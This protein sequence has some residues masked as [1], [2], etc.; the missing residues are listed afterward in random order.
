MKVN[1]P[2]ST[3]TP[4]TQLANTQE[5]SLTP[6]DFG[7]M[8]KD[9]SVEHKRTLDMRKQNAEGRDVLDLINEQASKGGKPLP[10][11]KLNKDDF[12]NLF[13]TQLKAQ[14]PTKP[15][16][17][18]QLA[19]QMSQFTS[20]E[21]L[22][23]VSKGIEK[24][25][26]TV[27]KGNR[28]DVINYIG[29][30][31]ET[32]GGRIHVDGKAARYKGAFTLDRDVTSGVI[33]VLNEQGSNV[34][35]IPVAKRKQGA[36]NFQWDGMMA[37]GKR[38]PAGNYRYE[39]DAMDVDGMKAKASVKSEAE[40]IGVRGGAGK[41]M[42][43]TEFGEFPLK[44]VQAI[45][46]REQVDRKRNASAPEKAMQQHQGATAAAQPIQQPDVA[47]QPQPEKPLIEKQPLAMPA[48]NVR[49]PRPSMQEVPVSAGL[50]PRV[51]AARLF[52]TIKNEGFT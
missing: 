22:L 31:I 7:R 48:L 41:P 6:F 25:I 10:K 9:S 45:K 42:L 44:D 1:A 20:M 24:L 46:T 40:V 36:N 3:L 38:A 15:M 23:S 2:Q 47:R 17:N 8:V 28:N 4:Q 49:K 19:E 13:V 43:L 33:K 35:R 51:A 29:K 11:Q 26:G 12:L 18:F 37:T 34:A 50:P 14:D 32:D 52:S 21:H 27:E 16:D 5:E 30:F 39:I